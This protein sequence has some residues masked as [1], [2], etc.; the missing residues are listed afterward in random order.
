MDLPSS[1]KTVKTVLAMTW[2]EAAS[3][4]G[5]YFVLLVF[6][7]FGERYNQLGELIKA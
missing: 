5:D 1:G 7:D 3:G 6:T 4:G 2:K